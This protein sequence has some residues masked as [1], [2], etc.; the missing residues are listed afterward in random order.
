LE[1]NKPPEGENLG[2][3]SGSLTQERKFLKVYSFQAHENLLLPILKDCFWTITAVDEGLLGV[4]DSTGRMQ[5]IIF[6]GPE[7]FRASGLLSI[8]FLQQPRK[9]RLPA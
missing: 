8:P 6:G 1:I 9:S 4:M 7:H 3:V 5:Q 2:V